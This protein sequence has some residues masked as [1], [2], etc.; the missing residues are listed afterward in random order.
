MLNPNQ[1][2]QRL[3]ANVALNPLLM[4]KTGQLSLMPTVEY[5]PA[6]PEPSPA[7]PEPVSAQNEIT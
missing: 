6:Q 3:A 4:E 1:L 2:P 5:E 7:P